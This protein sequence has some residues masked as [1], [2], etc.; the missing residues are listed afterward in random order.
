[1]GSRRFWRQLILCVGPGHQIKLIRISV[2]NWDKI[3]EKFNLFIYLFIF[4]GC[5]G[6]KENLN[7]IRIL[8]WIQTH[9]ARLDAKTNHDS[10]CY[11]VGFFFCFY[12]SNNPHLTPVLLQIS[13][14]I[15]NPNSSLCVKRIFQMTKKKKRASDL[16]FFFTKYI[17]FFHWPIL[18]AFRKIH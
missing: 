12:L 15:L 9:K 10:I 11:N 13:R 16:F 4:F 1:V 14:K 7:R 18:K 3:W 2:L 5:T 8:F 6:F 17:E